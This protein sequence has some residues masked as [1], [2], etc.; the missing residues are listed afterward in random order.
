MTEGEIQELRVMRDRI[1]EILKSHPRKPKDPGPMFTPANMAAGRDRERAS[2]TE[3]RR[4]R[5]QVTEQYRSI[6]DVCKR[7]LIQRT[8]PSAYGERQIRGMRACQAINKFIALYGK[9][10]FKNRGIS[11][12]H[13]LHDTIMDAITPER[14]I[15]SV[16][17]KEVLT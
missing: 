13:I 1:D 4:Q 16:E 12:A 7:E 11:D 8:T 15:E 9:L 2:Y 3:Q 14:F 5:E 6:G 17:D 10:E